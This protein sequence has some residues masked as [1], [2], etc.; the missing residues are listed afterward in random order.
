M[1]LDPAPGWRA[2]AAALPADP[3]EDDPVRF[4]ALLALAVAL[5]L[6]CS[7]ATE[8][9]VATET[10]KTDTACIEVAG[11]LKLSGIT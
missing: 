7:E 10:A 1:H 8:T 2:Y 9:P 3:D 11:F 6:A 5:G 4:P